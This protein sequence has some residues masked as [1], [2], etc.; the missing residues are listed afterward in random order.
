MPLQVILISYLKKIDVA[1]IPFKPSR[2]TE[3]VNPVKIYEY[4]AMGLNTVVLKYPELEKLGLDVSYY[5]DKEDLLKRIQEAL[6]SSVTHEQILYRRKSIQNETWKKRV[7][8]IYSKI[9][10]LW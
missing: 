10:K 5:S 4:L 1:L 9:E 8:Y 2:L 6:H 3:S 7:A